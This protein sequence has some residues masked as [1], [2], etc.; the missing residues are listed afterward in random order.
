M[1]S[2]ATGGR[3]APVDLDIF[4][5]LSS[6]WPLVRKARGW[7]S[8]RPAHTAAW[9]YRQN[10]RWFWIRSLPDTRRSIGYLPRAG[11]VRFWIWQRGNVRFRSAVMVCATTEH[12]PLQSIPRG[13]PDLIKRNPGV[14]PHLIGALQLQVGSR[15]RRPR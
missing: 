9:L 6:R 2:I 7:R 1:H 4:S 10:V 12:G 13:G 11:S 5:A 14:P 15:G 8:G 3:A